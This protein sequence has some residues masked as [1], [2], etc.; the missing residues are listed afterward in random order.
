MIFGTLHIAAY[1]HF[2]D[3][4]LSKLSTHFENLFENFAIAKNFS[5]D[6]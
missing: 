3:G 4:R 2:H 6:K 5:G 1:P